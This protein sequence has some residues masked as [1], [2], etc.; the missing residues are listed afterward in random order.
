MVPFLVIA[1]GAVLAS[2]RLE[3]SPAML[4]RLLLAGAAFAWVAF[5]LAGPFGLRHVV[6]SSP[7]E[8]ARVDAA[9]H[10]P[11]GAAV[12]ASQSMASLVADRTEIYSWPRPWE[13]GVFEGDP[14]SPGKRR[15]EVDWLLLDTAA[16]A[17]WSEDMAAA[18]ERIAPA[19]GF[20]LVWKREG[21][22]VYRRVR[23]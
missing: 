5:S 11:D 19:E 16:T 22:Q 9:E 2:R 21:V 18:V 13:G 20:V 4:G 3:A 8:E 23:S 15:A 1:A 10:V 6:V 14:V 7:L 17:Q 12:A